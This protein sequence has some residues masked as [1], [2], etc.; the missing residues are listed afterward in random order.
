M[1]EQRNNN[2]VLD[3]AA[4]VAGW[5]ED[6]QAQDIVGLDVRGLSEATDSM[7]IASARNLRHAQALADHLLHQV[8]DSKV[9]MLGM[10]GYKTGQWVLVDL[11]DVV[12]HIFQRDMREFF[13]LEGL[14]AQA[15][16]II[17]TRG[18]VDPARNN[19][20]DSLD[21]DE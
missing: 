12:V 4:Q 21:E 10:E 11:N 20:V 6:K 18:A 1:S 8:D 13:N 5:L 19:Q 17:D 14:W 2:T 3:T 16:I 7:I 9:E 15:Q